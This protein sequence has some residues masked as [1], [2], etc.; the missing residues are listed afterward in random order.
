MVGRLV[1][2]GG[3]RERAIRYSLFAIRDWLSIAHRPSPVARRLSLLAAIL[4]ALTTACS[5]GEVN[6]PRTTSFLV[7]HGVLNTTAPDQLVLL[8]RSLIG[9]VDIKTTNFNPAEPILSDGGVPVSGATAE[10]FGPD[11]RVVAGVE[12]RLVTANG[13]GAG[14]Y[15]FRISGTSLVRGQ[16]YRLHMR[17]REGE[18]LTATTTIPRAPSPP[19]STTIPF[20]RSKDVVN[21]TWTAVQGARSYAI[22]VETPFGPFFLFTDSLHVR[23]TGELR[24]LFAE[25]LPR[26]LIPGFEQGVLVAAA[27]SNFYDYYRTQNDPFT[28]SGIISRI[29]GGVGMF[30]SLAT[31]MTRVL[32]VSADR[33][34][35]I[36]SRFTYLVTA[37]SAR[38]IASEVNLYIESPSSR[39]DVPS[40][41]SG[42]YITPLQRT[43]GILGS[44]S[45]NNVVLALLAGQSAF[46][47]LSVFTGVLRGDTLAGS[48]SDRSG[49]AV[50]VRRR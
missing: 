44:Q 41:L 48:Y 11:G 9:A 28:G 32:D 3:R 23:L 22:R 19:P 24:N 25:D 47:T 4:F 31:V 34:Q 13:S 38:T 26:V 6:V 20:N 15:R 29:E 30:G 5:I 12:D 16:T 49:S 2:G 37:G 8:E 36:E 17:T 46:D 21:L 43:D 18:E 7:V 40:A 50:F 45:G 42:K 33:D 10:L 35:P 1:V 27:D 14:V 39:T